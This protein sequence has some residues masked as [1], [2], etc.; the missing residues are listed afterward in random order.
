MLPFDW[1]L[2]SGVPSPFR[3]GIF[4]VFFAVTVSLC[5]LPLSS[6]LTSPPRH[7]SPCRS[8]ETVSS[9]L[10]HCLPPASLGPECFL[11]RQLC[12]FLPYFI[13]AP[14]PAP[15]SWEPSLTTVSTT[16]FSR[17]SF[18]NL[19]ALFVFLPSTYSYVLVVCLPNRVYAPLGKG[20]CFVFVLFSPLYMQY[21]IVSDT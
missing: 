20:F 10:C 11:S 14:A 5:I 7:C 19:V 21:I 4:P 18:F 2:L 12:G 13:Q 6:P 9:F 16:V 3:T 1:S 15:A 8:S 17:L